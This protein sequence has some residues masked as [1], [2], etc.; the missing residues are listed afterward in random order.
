MVRHFYT[1]HSLPFAWDV[2]T[3]PTVE[4]SLARGFL[5]LFL[6]SSNILAS[7]GSDGSDGSDDDAASPFVASPFVASPFVLPFV[8]EAL[9]SSFFGGT[10]LKNDPET[11]LLLSLFTS[12][13]LVSLFDD[14]DELMLTIVFVE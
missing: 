6:I 7:N 1:N 2:G 8:T 11:L 14:D 10:G 9:S 4:G 5:F 13:S 12:S 3:P